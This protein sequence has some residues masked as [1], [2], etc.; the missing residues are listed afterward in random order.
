MRWQT[1]AVIPESWLYDIENQKEKFFNT[2]LNANQLHICFWTDEQNA[3]DSKGAILET[4]A[5][6]F[7][8]SWTNEFP[9]EGCYLCSIVKA[10]G[11]I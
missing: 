8:S 7:N 5:P 1:F 3:R 10:R 2:G 11:N 4:Y 9:D 6:N